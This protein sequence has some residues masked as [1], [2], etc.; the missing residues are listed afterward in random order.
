MKRYF[1]ITGVL[2]LT[3]C[4]AEPEMPTRAE[5]RVI[6]VENCAICHGA[7]GKGDGEVASFLER[8]PSDLT[9]LA[10]SNDGMFDRAEVLSMIDGYER[11]EAAGTDM[12]EFG[13]LLRGDTVP[14][15]V[16]DGV[17]TPTPRPLAALMLYLER[18]QR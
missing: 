16:G 3:A 7:S 18:L 13:L 17:M 15:D 2:A 4:I 1:V 5:G 14:V 8:R 6:Y 11:P 9:L 12:P 10:K